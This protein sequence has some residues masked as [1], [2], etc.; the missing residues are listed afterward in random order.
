MTERSQQPTELASWNR[1]REAYSWGAVAWTCA[2]LLLGLASLTIGLGLQMQRAHDPLGGRFFPV[3]VSALLALAAVAVLASPLVRMAVGLPVWA[4]ADP[5]DTLDDADARLLDRPGV[6]V[7][8]MMALCIGYAG[9]L[10]LIG[11]VPASVLALAG[12]MYLLGTRGLRGL[13]VMPVLAATILYAV[14]TYALF[15][16]LP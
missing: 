7:P 8:A 12:C 13:V 9:L 4:L 16:R 6:R 1:L 11:Y 2:L 15:V 3:A 10:P 5:P 14:F